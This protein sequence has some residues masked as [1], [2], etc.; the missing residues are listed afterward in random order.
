MFSQHLEE[1]AREGEAQVQLAGRPFR[2][3]QQFVEDAGGHNLKVKIATLRRALLVMH[4]PGDDT[5]GLSNAMEIFTAAK[6]PKSF[7]SLDSADHLL[8]RREDA[9]YVANLI[10]TWAD[11]Y[12]A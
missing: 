8:T 6:H 9:V 12:L 1:I 10:A 3:K 2:I 7:I 11:R 5:V 4:A